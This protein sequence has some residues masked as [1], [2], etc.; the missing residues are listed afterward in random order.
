MTRQT[1]WL[2]VFIYKSIFSSSLSLYIVII[3]LDEPQLNHRLNEKK[4]E[5]KI[6]NKFILR[7]NT[8]IR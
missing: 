6:I 5:K 4:I 7:L 1:D 8:R 3:D 2:P